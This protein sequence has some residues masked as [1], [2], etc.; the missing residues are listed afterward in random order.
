MVDVSQ[1]DKKNFGNDNAICLH[2]YC[3]KYWSAK[4]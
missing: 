1:I 3:V 2:K 4:L